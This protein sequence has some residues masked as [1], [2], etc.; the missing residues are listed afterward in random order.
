MI[1]VIPFH[2]S[3]LHLV[4]PKLLL[5]QKLAE[6]R[7]VPHHLMLAHDGKTVDRAAYK[8]VREFGGTVFR[9]CSG[10]PIEVGNTFQGWPK[11]ANAMFLEVARQIKSCYKSHWLWLEPDAWPLHPAWADVLD[12]GY[13]QAHKRY[14][15]AEVK[16]TKIGQ[17]A[18]HLSGVAVYP[19][20]AFNDFEKFCTGDT[21]FDYAAAD[22]VAPMS[23][24]T[25]LIQHVWGTKDLSPTFVDQK[26]AGTPANALL[27]SDLDP[28]A[29]IFHRCKDLSL[30]RLLMTGSAAEPQ[31]VAPDPQAPA[32]APEP[33]KPAVYQQDIS[34]PAFRSPFKGTPL[35]PPPRPNAPA[36]A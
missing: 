33:P 34:G 2:A 5:I 13:R 29:V 16:G 6:S 31:A 28:Q 8:E 1:I 20:D 4:L 22:R 24:F 35:P 23:E 27:H 30:H 21:A 7:K 14:F 25:S 11:A 10:L 32:A 17:P 15:G 18:R 26:M 12:K 36:A 3:D 19:S 9:S